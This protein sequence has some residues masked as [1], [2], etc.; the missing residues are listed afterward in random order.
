MHGV[1]LLVCAQ[2]MYINVSVC[3]YMTYIY[4]YACVYMMDQRLDM[5]TH[6]V[7]PVD[8]D[9]CKLLYVMHIYTLLSSPRS[10]V[11]MCCRKWREVRQRRRCV[12]KFR[13]P[14]TYRA[15]DDTQSTYYAY[16]MTFAGS[17]IECTYI[18]IRLTVYF[19]TELRA[20]NAYHI[21]RFT[22]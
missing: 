16:R 15:G 22:C 10:S 9:R 11:N 18:Y 8:T 13:I 20:W 21:I 5:D 4:M 12:R 6:S 17:Y 7:R 1:Y 2:C 14:R 3:I 19:I